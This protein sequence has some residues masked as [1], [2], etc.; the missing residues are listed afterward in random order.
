MPVVSPYQARKACDGDTLDAINEMTRRPGPDTA[1]D[2]AAG[3]MGLVEGPQ[4]WWSSLEGL[5]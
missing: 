2:G 3:R 4:A 5:F 1:L